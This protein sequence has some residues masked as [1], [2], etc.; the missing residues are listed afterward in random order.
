MVESQAEVSL[1]QSG[2]YMQGNTPYLLPNYGSE[3]NWYKNLLVD[4]T[5][6]ISVS[7][8]GDEEI[9]ARGKP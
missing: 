2:L 7:G 3:T 8:G 5:L 1:D 9:P 4:P 6:K